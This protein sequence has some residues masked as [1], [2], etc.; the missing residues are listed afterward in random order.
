MKQKKCLISGSFDPITKGHEEM[1]KRA[2][3]LFDK[4]DIVIFENPEKRYLFPLETRLD[5][6]KTL[7]GSNEKIHVCASGGLLV[8]YVKANEITAVLR[9]IRNMADFEYEVQMEQ[10]NKQLNPNCECVYLAPSPNIAQISSSI[11]RQLLKFGADISFAVP[12]EIQSKI[13]A[14]YSKLNNN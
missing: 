6:I 8:D 4:V 3:N 1:I 13:K 12:K 9:G 7:C 11:V 5:F 14:E 10:I 2:L